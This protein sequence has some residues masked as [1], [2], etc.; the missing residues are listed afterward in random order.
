MSLLPKLKARVRMGSE[1]GYRIDRCAP[2]FTS[3]IMDQSK[4]TALNPSNLSH[5]VSVM[6]PIIPISVT[7]SL[8]G[9]VASIRILKRE[10]RA[11]KFKE[12]YYW[13]PPKKY[14]RVNKDI[15]FSVFFGLYRTSFFTE[16]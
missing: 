10:T 12:F 8:I 1:N 15:L 13:N 14:T 9:I 16:L 7:F 6:E 11:V 5:I 2:L 3:E 4:L